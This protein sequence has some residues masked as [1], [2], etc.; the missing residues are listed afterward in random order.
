MTSADGAGWGQPDPGTGAPGS[1]PGPQDPQSPPAPPQ[2]GQPQYG[3]PQYGQPQYG[4]PQYGQ[5][6][7]GQPQYG[8]PQYGQPQYGQPQYGQPQYGQGPTGY[9]PP[10]GFSGPPPSLRPGIISLRPLSLGE[11]FD[12]AFGAIRTNPRVMVGL[13]TLVVAVSV[14]LG[15]LGQQLLTNALPQVFG[16]GLDTIF[17]EEVSAADMEEFRSAMSPL[18]STILLTPVMTFVITPVMAGLLTVS[19][20]RSVLGHKATVGE[21]WAAT[22]PSIWRLIGLSLLLG[23]GSAIV[24]AGSLALVVLG[25]IP[26]IESTDGAAAGVLLILV[27][28]LG[29]IVGFMWFAVRT[30]LM[31][32][33]LVLERVSIRTAISRGWTLTRGGFWRLLGI[34]LL[35]QVAVGIVGQI[36]SVPIGLIGGLAGTVMP[37]DAMMIAITAFS[38][39][40][41]YVVTISFLSAL[42]ALIYIDV[43]MRREGLDVELAAAAA[44]ENS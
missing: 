44:R 43:R 13:T 9:G 41:T 30:M 32:P 39:L 36:L 42:I 14:A 3:Q 37:L 29:L 2:Y 26:L 15:I 33:A 35:A 11:L 18:I 6:Q 28:S 23:L 38:L 21:T 22:R 20:S 12:G 31:A 34:Y 7:Y 16:A 10:Q 1:R 8:Q 4:Q 25:A 40:V 27:L 5:P 17:G 24:I 19:V